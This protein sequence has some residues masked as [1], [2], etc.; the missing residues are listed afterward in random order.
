MKLY[1]VPRDRQKR[2]RMLAVPTLPHASPP[3]AEGEV[4]TFGHVDGMYSFCTN[5][6]GQI[7]HPAAW[8]E[9]EVVG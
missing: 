9:V 5:D 4:L 3:I 1:E 6:K 2:V 7:V 8:T